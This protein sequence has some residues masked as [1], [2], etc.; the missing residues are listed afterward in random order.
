MFFF[1]S[2]AWEFEGPT[3]IYCPS[4][5]MTE[6]VTVE[7]RKLNLACGTYHA[8]MNNSSR[9]EVH[10]KFM[11]DEIQVKID[12]HYCLSSIVVTYSSIY[13]IFFECL[14]YIEHKT[15]LIKGIRV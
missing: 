1:F 3:I 7:L 9:K 14:L 8:G 13:Q 12:H 2:S 4:R 6:Q 15:A 11:R 10:H 5:K